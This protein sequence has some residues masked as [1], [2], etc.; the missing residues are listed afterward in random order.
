MFAQVHHPAMRYVAPVRKKLGIRTVFNLLGPLTNPAGANL[1]LMGVYQESLLQPMAEV[2]MEL[3]VKRAMVVHGEDGLDEITLTTTTQVR[4]ICD[5]K[6][7]AY[8]IDPEQYGMSY[9][10]SEDLVGGDPQKNKQIALDILQGMR[11]PK[12]DVVLLNAAACIHIATGCGLKAALQQAADLLDQGKA[13][14][15]LQKFIA[16]T[17]VQEATAV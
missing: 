13:Y 6:I 14:E 11:G 7:T 9:C 4:E 12:R 16:A 15:Q 3:G 2:L 17:N 1:Q 8:T 5:G 10:R